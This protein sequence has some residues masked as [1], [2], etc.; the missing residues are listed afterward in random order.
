MPYHV[1]ISP[2]DE[3]FGIQKWNIDEQTLLDQ[4]VEPYRQGEPITTDGKTTNMDRLR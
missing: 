1:W 4:F 3:F 2:E